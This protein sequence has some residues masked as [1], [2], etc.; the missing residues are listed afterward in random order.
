[1][2]TASAST[3]AEARRSRWTWLGEGTASQTGAGELPLSRVRARPLQSHRVPFVPA[4]RPQPRPTGVDS[5]QRQIPSLPCLI[6]RQAAF[7][8]QREVLKGGGDLPLL[9]GIAWPVRSRAVTTITSWP[10]KPF[11]GGGK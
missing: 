10:G 8:D 2:K 7:P 3:L 6:T 1:M 9:A 4:D 11:R 5:S